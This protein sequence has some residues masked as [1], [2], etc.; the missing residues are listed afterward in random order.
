MIRE[1]NENDAADMAEL[2]KQLSPT[3]LNMTDEIVHQIKTKI[4]EMARLGYMKIFGYQQDERI[5]G[6]CSIGKMEGI[7][8]ECRPFAVIENV[9]VLDSARSNG[10]GRQLVRH[11]MDQAENW[12]CYKVILETG[13]QDE[14]KLRFYEK[15]GLTRGG[16]TAFIKR[17]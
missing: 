15:C 9:V 11:A 1:I 5:I 7:T 17:F 13:T 8:K 10:I 4:S 14:W 2:V 3:E 16:K 12:D 6:T